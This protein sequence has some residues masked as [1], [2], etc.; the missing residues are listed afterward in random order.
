MRPV[1]PAPDGALMPAGP[2]DLLCEVPVPLRMRFADDLSRHLARHC[3]QGGEAFS[4]HVPMGQGGPSPLDRL[5]YV[6]DPL[7]FPR[8]LVSARH[9]NAFNRR[10][11]DTHMRAGAFSSGQ[12]AGVASVFEAAGL[13]D[14][15]GWIGVYA[16]APF[17]MLVDRAR[18]GTR[19]LPRSWADLAEPELRG[20]VSFGGWRRPGMAHHSALNTFFLLAMLRLLG[21]ER[22]GR[23]LA[24]VSELTH[25]AQMPRIA[26]TGASVSSIYVLPWSLADICPRRN[27]T[28][29]V[30]PREGALAYPLWTTMQSA[31]RQR[32]APVVDHLYGTATADFLDR[33]R[34]PALAPRRQPA[35]PEGARLLWP[36][37]DYVRHPAAASDLK[38]VIALFRR[39]R[40]QMER[41]VRRCA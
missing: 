35:L 33:N 37:W 30:W 2:L 10:F 6:R 15:K 7:D 18:L 19:P 3:T 22:F 14:P 38:H 28:E 20:E 40:E 26:G 24:N 16:V 27:R 25:S 17:V 13:I 4:C 31:H 8:M 29:V 23:L 12:P 21:P 41:E 11:H 5:R 1:M 32:L 9:G 34:Y 39:S 36:G